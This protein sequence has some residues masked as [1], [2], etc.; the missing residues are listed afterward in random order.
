MYIKRKS[1]TTPAVANATASSA[2]NRAPSTSKTQVSQTFYDDT[3]TKSVYCQEFSKETAMNPARR[4][5][6]RKG[7]RR[8]RTRLPDRQERD[9]APTLRTQ[10]VFE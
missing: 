6:H 10:S 8:A 9:A 2:N 5:H 3:N 7:P 1:A 4:Q